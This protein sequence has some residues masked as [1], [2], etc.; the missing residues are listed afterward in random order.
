MRGVKTELLTLLPIDDL[1]S[2]QRRGRCFDGGKRNGGRSHR[3]RLSH[4]SRLGVRS[5]LLGLR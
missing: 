2:R 3:L 1:L 4:R 5:L